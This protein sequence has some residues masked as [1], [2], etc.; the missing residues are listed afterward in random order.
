MFNHVSSFDFTELER[1]TVDGKRYY[2]TPTGLLYP[3]VTT[4]LSLHNAQGIQEWR[5]RVGEEEANRVSRR[6]SGRGTKVHK[7][8]EDYL[9]NKADYLEGHMPSNVEMFYSLKPVLDTFIDNIV[10]QEA[11]L[12]SDYLQVGGQV[13]CIADF[14]GTLSVI[15]FKTASREKSEDYIQSY[16]M[17]TAA[18][19]VMFEEMTK[20]PIKQIVII[21]AVSNDDRN[22]TVQTFV[23]DRDQYIWDFVRLRE[24]YRDIHGV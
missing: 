12:Y 5:K 3:S 15:D 11:P 13:D 22:H 7:L 2:K 19:C 14:N 17:Q 18:Y 10:V 1:E 8:C 21:I 23:K 16:F 6:A 9:N 24:S 20:Q 4:V